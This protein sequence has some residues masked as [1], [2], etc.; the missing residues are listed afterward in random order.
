[1]NR[2]VTFGVTQFACVDDAA[3][4]VDRAEAL[5]RR[6]G[7]ARRECYPA[8]GAVRDALFL[9]NGAARNISA[10]A[11]L[12]SRETALVARFA[13][14][15]RELGVVLPRQLLRARRPSAFQQPRHGRR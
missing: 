15:A 9:Q 1:M 13:A 2:T 12:C 11:A 5:V 10:L 4:N 8:A 14:L 3:A 7:P 6:G